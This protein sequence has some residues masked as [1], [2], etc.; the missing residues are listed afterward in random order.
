MDN[1]I[2]RITIV[3]GG[4]AGWLTA[5]I[6]NRFLS[7]PGAPIKV[8]LIESPNI[9]T[10]GVGEATLI[11]LPRLMQQLGM[12]EA[13][14][15]R[16]T[17]GAFKLSVCFDDW[18]IDGPERPFRFYHPFNNPDDVAPAY[19]FHR[20][21]PRRPGTSLADN[22]IVNLAVIRAGK[23]PRA[24]SAGNYGQEVSYAYHIDAGLFAE[25]M[26]DVGTARGIEH[27][28]DDVVD[29]VMDEAGA[30]SG[31]Q[32]Q[33]GGH[34]PV[35]F[36]VDCTGFRSLIIDRVRKEPF[37]SFGDRLLNDR[38]IPVQIPHR[39]PTK[40]EPCT[41]ATALGAGWVWRVPLYSRV[42]TGYVYSSAFRS[43]DEARAEFFAHLRAIGDLTAD[44][45][46]PE[47]R[48][49][50]MKVGYSREPWVKNCLAIGLAGG[51]VEPLEATAI[52]T[53]EA[54][55]RLFILNFPDKDRSPVL[56]KR[57]NAVM[58]SLYE[59]IRDFIETHYI[60]SNRPEPYWVA[61]RNDVAMSEELREHFELWRHRLPDPTD[62]DKNLVFGAWNYIFVLHAKG[63]FKDRH[64]P[65]EGP[66]SRGD[67]EAYGRHLEA[68]KAQTVAILPDHYKLLTGI[69]AQSAELPERGT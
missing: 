32:L 30:I 15:M 40:I 9:A 64:F 35:E 44:A 18:F 57:Y 14:L 52:F 67:W 68:T 56:T 61:A 1:R 17:N 22:M 2:E 51:F 39:D 27:V 5:M 66:V 54:A 37:I 36:V 43:D 13:E 34:H 65:L 41:R 38:A 31:L 23:G 69:R 46:D 19:A 26:R 10:V 47:T 59:N 49:I 62:F 3:G 4:T 16:R 29:V 63:F 25:Y 60:T 50:K 55:A 45:P 7:P 11:A 42:G 20:Y 33:R 53:I 24:I 48:V 8:T 6:L 21:G 12:D 28:R 58:T